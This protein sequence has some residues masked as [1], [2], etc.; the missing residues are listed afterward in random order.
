LST[1]NVLSQPKKEMNRAELE[2]SA[3]SLARVLEAAPDFANGWFTL[4]EMRRQLGDTGAAIAAFRRV[5]DLD[6]SDIFGAGLRLARLG[7]ITPDGMPEAYVRGMFD[8]YAPRFDGELVETLGY[9]APALLR[10]AAEAACKT[11]G[12]VAAFDTMLDLGCGT[13][14]SG[15]AFRDC[16]KHLTGVD[17]SS[18]MI[19]LARQKNIYDR[20]EA[21]DIERFLAGE[22]GAV[23][24]YSLIVAA[25]V[26]T[27]L[28]SLTG[29]CAAVARVM[30]D[31]ALF[32]LTVETYPGDGV[33]L[34]EGLRYAHGAAH[35]RSA[36]AGLEILQLTEVSTRNEA[37][38]PVPGLLVVA[39]RNKPKPKP[40]P[41]PK[42]RSRK[43]G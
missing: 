42:T 21:D 10:A 32:A 1:F 28:G 31:G 22:I 14:L 18:G 4:G 7:A 37:G 29:V 24:T 15:A 5:I 2:A 16:V 3:A 12:R 26:F 35:V 33:A 43:A 19:A 30:S 38:M 9:R 23:R 8:Q 34:G 27:Y 25:D 13:G 40:K 36:L 20:L 41:K 39:Q 11:Q 6:P 17:L